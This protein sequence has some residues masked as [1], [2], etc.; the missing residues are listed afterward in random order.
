MYFLKTHVPDF[1]QIFSP[2]GNPKNRKSQIN[3]FLLFLGLPAEKNK[4]NMFSKKTSIEKRI[5]PATALKKSYSH[6]IEILQAKAYVYNINGGYPLNPFVT[7]F[8]QKSRL[9]E[10]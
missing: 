3:G 4:E 2:A 5:R 8:L 7:S 10:V 1:F 6:F 9:T